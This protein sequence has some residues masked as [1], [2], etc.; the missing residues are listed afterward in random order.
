MNSSSLNLFV[1]SS[2]FVIKRELLTGT[3]SPLCCLNHCSWLTSLCSD[4][5]SCFI[6]H[7]FCSSNTLIIQFYFSNL[8]GVWNLWD[9]IRDTSTFFFSLSIFSITLTFS[10]TLKTFL[11]LVSVAMLSLYWFPIKC[12]SGEVRGKLYVQRELQLCCY[13]PGMEF[14]DLH[15][16][17]EGLMS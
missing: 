6:L 2:A 14:I 13:Y 7:L 3:L 11:L 8:F 4:F 15:E 1:N 5:H 10:L 16:R 17:V 9:Q 12:G